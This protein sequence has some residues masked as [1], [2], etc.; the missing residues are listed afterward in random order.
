MPRIKPSL[1]E[2][3]NRELPPEKLMEILKK[4]YTPEVAEEIFERLMKED[5]DQ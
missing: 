4:I 2:R 1:K 3:N 5:G